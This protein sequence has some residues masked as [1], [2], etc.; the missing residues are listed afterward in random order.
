MT[1]SPNRPRKT[2]PAAETTEFSEHK[3]QQ[4]RKRDLIGKLRDGEGND[5][6]QQTLDVFCHCS[7]L[8]SRLFVKENRILCLSVKYARL[9]F[10]TL[11]IL[12]NCFWRFCWNFISSG[13][14]CHVV[15]MTIKLAV[16]NVRD[17]QLTDGPPWPLLYVHAKDVFKI[18]K[19][20]SSV[21]FW[22]N[23]DFHKHQEVPFGPFWHKQQAPVIRRSLNSI[24]PWI[25]SLSTARWV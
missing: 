5:W 6:Q 7:W 20:C 13:L 19:M 1:L 9:P 2:W 16:F 3:H 4:N 8:I 22:T 12:Y 14:S 18:P 21:N 11:I 25:Y 10:F 23:V 15:S 24:I 17:T